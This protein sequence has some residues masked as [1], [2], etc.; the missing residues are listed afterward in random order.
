[1][2]IEKNKP[3][4]FENDVEG[5]VQVKNLVLL[6]YYAYKLNDIYSYKDFV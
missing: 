2:N 6:E 1:M 5:E 4:N 3:K